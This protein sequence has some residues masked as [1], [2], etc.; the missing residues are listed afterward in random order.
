MTARALRRAEVTGDTLHILNL[1]FRKILT[2]ASGMLLT[3]IGHGTIMNGIDHCTIMG[4]EGGVA[5]PGWTMVRVFELW[6]SIQYLRDSAGRKRRRSPSPYDRD[7]F[8][9]R[10]RYNDDYGK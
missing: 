5:A 1:D 7:R 6:Y 4:V 9:P 3:E 8:E 10:P 2:G